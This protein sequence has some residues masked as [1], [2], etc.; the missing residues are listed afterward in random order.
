MDLTPYQLRHHFSFW[1]LRAGIPR[2]RRRAY[3]GHDAQDMTDRYEVHEIDM[4]LRE[5]AIR[6][7][8]YLETGERLPL[9]LAPETRLLGPV[10]LRL[11]PHV[12]AQAGQV[13]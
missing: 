1:M 7:T 3:L 13:A 6:L 10:P 8:H 5:D 11:L 9:E 4:Y 2:D 12:D